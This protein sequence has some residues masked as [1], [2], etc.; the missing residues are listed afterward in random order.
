MN[1]PI[2]YNTTHANMG[3][4]SLIRSVMRWH[5]DRNTIHG[6]TNIQ[7]LPKLLE[8]MGE[9]AGNLARGRDRKDDY[10]DILVVLLGMMERD[11]LTMYECLLRS[12]S[13]I[14]DRKGR[15]E[16]GIFIKE[17]D[18]EPT[19]EHKEHYKYGVNNNASIE[20]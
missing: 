13:D 12:Y 1:L 3:I 11:G 8:E 10:G 4:D 14:K 18:F 19:L 15:M 7:Q 16:D 6:G 9:L 20:S 17:A 5:Y 2:E